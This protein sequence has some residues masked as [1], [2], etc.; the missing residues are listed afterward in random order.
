MDKPDNIC[1]VCH[2][3][4]LPEY[5]F[6]PNCG[7]NLREALRPVSIV[8]Q[9]GLYIL[10]IFLPPLG[11][12]PGVKYLMKKGK[13]P[14]LVG[15]ITIVLTIVSTILTIMFTFKFLNNYLSQINEYL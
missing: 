8:N 12:W 14:K 5:Y 15:V 4:I 13:Q 2:Q 3:I 7:N 1:S 10:A 9:I 6:C 11:L